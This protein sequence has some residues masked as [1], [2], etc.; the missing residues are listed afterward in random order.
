LHAGRADNEGAL[1]DA[2]PAL[3]TGPQTMELRHLRY[4]VAVSTTA[5]ASERS[6]LAA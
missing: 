2:A 5:L 4:V 3:D 6:V 1:G